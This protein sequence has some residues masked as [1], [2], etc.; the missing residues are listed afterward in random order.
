MASKPPEEPEKGV[1]TVDVELKAMNAISK[2][3]HEL[4]PSVRNRVLTY[5]VDRYL[6]KKEANDA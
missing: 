4:E 2:A 1:I 3:L 5:F 6:P